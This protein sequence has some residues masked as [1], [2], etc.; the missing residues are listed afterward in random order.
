M[1]VAEDLQVARVQNGAHADVGDQRGQDL[2]RDD[3]PAVVPHGVGEDAGR[4]ALA[5]GAHPLP[6]RRLAGL[7]CCDAITTAIGP[8]GVSERSSSRQV[9]VILLLKIAGVGQVVDT[10]AEEG[11]DGG[12]EVESDG[13]GGESTHAGGSSGSGSVGARVPVGEIGGDHREDTDDGRVVLERRLLPR[14]SAGVAR[15]HRLC[16]ISRR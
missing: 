15:V 6:P 14:A 8:V 7:P 2:V 16:G 10:G 9:T 3:A 11:L 5:H 1:Q 12:A 13:L 4:G